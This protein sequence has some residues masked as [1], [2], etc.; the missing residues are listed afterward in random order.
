MAGETGGGGPGGTFPFGPHHFHLLRGTR[1]TQYITK[2]ALFTSLGLFSGD[3]NSFI[4][5][6]GPFET[7]EGPFPRGPQGLVPS[8]S[9]IISP[10]LD[11]KRG[12]D[13]GQLEGTRPGTR[14]RQF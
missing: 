6:F 1:G 8:T 3:C 4:C 2:W 7:L 12:H 14:F 11:L 9:R 13:P 5:G 10:A